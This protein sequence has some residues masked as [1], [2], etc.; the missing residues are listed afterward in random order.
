MAHHDDQPGS[1]GHELIDAQTFAAFGADFVKNDDCHVV[2]ADAFKDY[3]AMQ[4]AIAQVDRPMQHAVKIYDLNPAT[5]PQV[6][7]YRRVGG[8]L[9]NSW[10]NVMSMLDRGDDA[11]FAS[12]PGKGK[13]FFNDFGGTS[14]RLLMRCV[15][16][17][18]CHPRLQ[19]SRFRVIS[20]ADMM[21]IGL[22][23]FWPQEGNNVPLT[24]DENE[25]HFSL[26]WEPH[27]LVMLCVCAVVCHPPAR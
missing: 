6:A 23:S 10:M 3:L 12:V 18:V 7:Q 4:D 11:F 25:A 27:R 24:R 14:R 1:L 19:V 20:R 8:D 17:A 5:A 16:A 22:R 13:G 9:H 15:C 2:Y 26:W 21:V